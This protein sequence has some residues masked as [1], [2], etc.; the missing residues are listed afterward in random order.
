MTAT[1]WSICLEVY[2][3]RR[4]KIRCEQTRRHYRYSLNAFADYLGREPELTD[5]NEDCVTLWVGAMLTRGENKEDPRSVSTSLS[6]V[7]RVITLWR[8]LFHKRI[9]E[10]YPLIELPSAPEPMPLALSEGELCKLFE[11][12]QCRPGFV[13]GIPARYYW[14]ALFG[15]VFNTSERK[16]GTM[17]T[18]R[19]WVNLD[20]R[21]AVVPANVRKGK[22]KTAT[23]PLW[24][25]VCWLLNRIWNPVRDR[26]FP[27]E[28]R[29]HR[30]TSKSGES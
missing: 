17:A 2:F 7:T 13:C 16:G 22:R 1:L 19:E 5:L 11:A 6:Y 8:F 10:S 25:E 29:M 4:L 3:P 9:A 18:L 28:S 26:M 27:W 20:N 24:E 12:A 30:F 14:P 21:V 15:F 23:Y